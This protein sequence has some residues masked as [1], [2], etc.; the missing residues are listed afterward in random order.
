MD[1]TD[2]NLP[3]AETDLDILEK[4][5][6]TTQNEVHADGICSNQIRTSHTEN[7]IGM[8]LDEDS[9]ENPLST[10]ETIDSSDILLKKQA[11]KMA[12]TLPTSC[13]ATMAIREIL[14][15]ST[16]VCTHIFFHCLYIC[17]FWCGSK[18]TFYLGC[19]F[20]FCH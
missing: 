7:S 5:A 9:N 10:I 6:N 4:A 17:T 15:S 19:E 12:F 14:K 3:L 1:Y 8:H 16:S 11:L 18:L 13:Y 20:Y 2:D